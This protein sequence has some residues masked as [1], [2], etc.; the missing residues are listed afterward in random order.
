MK[1]HCV[2]EQSPLGGILSLISAWDQRASCWSVSTGRYQNVPVLI[3]LMNGT[4]LQSDEE[5]LLLP[6]V[7]DWLINTVALLILKEKSSST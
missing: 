6:I 3:R 2:V 7:I 1:A 4:L 5:S